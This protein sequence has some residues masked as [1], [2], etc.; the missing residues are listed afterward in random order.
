MEKIKFRRYEV[1]TIALDGSPA[2]KG[3]EQIGTWRRPRKEGSIYKSCGGVT[4]K[5]LS[6]KPIDPDQDLSV[7][8]FNTAPG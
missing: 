5:V 2:V 8:P 6:C 4:L 7:N 3:Q 1:K